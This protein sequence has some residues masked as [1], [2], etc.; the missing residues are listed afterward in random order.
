[1]E[2]VVSHDGKEIASSSV[3]LAN[4]TAVMDAAS[5]AFWRLV[6]IALLALVVLVFLVIFLNRSIRHRKPVVKYLML[7]L[8]ITLAALAGMSLSISSVKAE[9]YYECSQSSGSVR[10]N[11]QDVV[12][13]LMQNNPARLEVRCQRE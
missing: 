5:S 7:L 8:P 6:G 12:G 4:A 3:A 9:T 2:I 13:G 10:W 1:L 11:E